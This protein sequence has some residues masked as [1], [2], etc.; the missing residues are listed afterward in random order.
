MLK[1]RKNWKRCWERVKDTIKIGDNEMKFENDKINVLINKK[2]YL[3]EINIDNKINNNL[4]SNILKIKNNPK[5]N[6][7]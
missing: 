3:W 6:G 4:K 5:N 1:S 2:R 7:S